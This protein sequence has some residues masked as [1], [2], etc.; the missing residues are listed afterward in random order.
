MLTSRRISRAADQS[1][2]RTPDASGRQHPSGRRNRTKLQVFATPA[3][4]PGTRGHPGTKKQRFFNAV[5]V[6]PVSPTILHRSGII[7]RLRRRADR[8]QDGQLVRQVA[9][10]KCLRPNDCDVCSPREVE[11]NT[12]K[13]LTP[14]WPSS[15]R[16][17]RRIYTTALRSIRVIKPPSVSFSSCPSMRRSVCSRRG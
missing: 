17:V 12:D 7:H 2:L 15:A 5:P 4:R 6:S 14:G 13:L 9:E 8:F 11:P 1:L 16:C 3:R 10:M